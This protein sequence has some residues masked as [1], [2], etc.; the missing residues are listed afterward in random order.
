MRFRTLILAISI[1]AMG[2]ALYGQSC[3][4]YMLR[5]IHGVACS[6]WMSMAPGQPQVPFTALGT[7][8]TDSSG[9]VTG[10]SMI[11]I[12]GA[13]FTQTVKGQATTNDDC[14]GTI[15]Y[16]QTINGQPVPDTKIFFV[17]YDSG[18]SIQGTSVDPG[19]TILCT[20]KRLREY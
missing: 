1:L 14:T 2:P 5:G 12:G 9:A 13:S 11:S 6:G 20:V 16:K 3:A 17:V 4:N 10:T 15:T 19:A 8:V 18:K 7:T